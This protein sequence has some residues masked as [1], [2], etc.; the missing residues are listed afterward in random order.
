MDFY[1][2]GTPFEY[3]VQLVPTGASKNP[4]QTLL[5]GILDRG[6]EV[7][8]PGKP[9]KDAELKTA[10][11]TLVQ[12]ISSSSAVKDSTH[13]TVDW[14]YG[15]GRFS[16]VPLVFFLDDR[17]T[18][19]IQEGVYAVFLFR[20]DMSGVYLTFNQGVTAIQKQHGRK[21]A[22]QIAQ[23]QAEDLRTWCANLPMRGFKL[24]NAIDLHTEDGLALE[25]QAATIAHKLYERG[26]VPSDSEI[27][28]DVGGVLES[29]RRYA[30]KDTTPPR[31][32]RAWIF[33]ANP[34]LFD[35]T[36]AVHELPELTFEVNQHAKEIRKGDTAFLWASGKTAGVVAIATVI[37]DPA[38]G[39]QRAE[40][41]R[42]N[43]DPVRF[44]E[45]RARSV[46]RINYVPPELL[47]RRVLLD[48][49]VL[50]EIPIL[51]GP[52]GTNFGLTSEQAEILS[53]LVKERHK[54]D[55]VRST[56][57]VKVTAVPRL[58]ADCLAG[59]FIALDSIKPGGLDSLK[60][61]RAGDIVVAAR[62]TSEVLAVGEVI[63]PGY[64]W[65]PERAEG[66]HTVKV[67]WKDT[68]PKRIPRQNDWLLNEVAAIPESLLPL[69]L[70]PGPETPPNKD[71]K[72][73]L[74]GFNTAL[75][76][77]RL[78]FGNEDVVRSFV[79]GLATKRL[80]ILTG[81]SGSG[82]TQ[83]ALRFG[84]WFGRDQ[85]GGRRWALVP[86][87]PDW[88]GPE[89]LLGYEDAL[90]NSVGDRQVWHVP[91]VLDFILR[92]ARNPDYPYL[93]VLDEMN[94]A[95]VERYFADF[96]SGMESGAP[97]LPNLTQAGEKWLS[98]ADPS[99]QIPLPENVFVVGTV[100]VD[101]TTYMF[102]PKV[103][104][105]ANTYEFRVRTKDLA[106][107]AHKPLPCEPGDDALVRGFLAI[108]A[109][110]EWQ[111]EQPAPS[112]DQLLPRITELHGLL[113]EHDLE[114]GH[115]VFYDMIRFAAMLSAT[116]EK[117]PEVTLDRQVF[118]KVLP[119]LH[120]TRR[121]LEQPLRTLAQ[122][123][124]NLKYQPNVT[125][126]FKPEEPPK[127]KAALPDSFEKLQRM[128]KSLRINQFTSF[129][130]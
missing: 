52:Q 106:Q 72:Q 13:I 51:K 110:D 10:F 44:A 87:R 77:T 68:H 81:L 45:D 55:V 76:G 103:L 25:Y 50:K 82:K 69:V 94:L 105:R 60:A 16:A 107:V 115:R 117:R 63:S 114:F 124:F 32:P 123:C 8:E 121:R 7:F 36:D 119:R 61:L 46:L 109:D 2:T 78:T 53:A 83:L 34:E 74:A 118:Q 6:A 75:A 70:R 97:C 95:H 80:A 33:Q 86:V 62:G 19:S 12:T 100:N 5:Q 38:S 93:L 122:F 18:A 9:A 67:H 42:F 120:G 88:T 90:Q 56:V 96:L 85:D 54:P 108:A 48:H 47:P 58:W 127:G 21:M 128:Y 79:A 111:V 89:A 91:P 30:E 31:L 64:Q 102:S 92:A 3:R 104:D 28:A 4:I 17:I 116:D 99:D 65:Q 49:P 43:R 26:H 57:A 15:K 11:E 41:K 125:V 126:D 113:A 84:E 98:P 66:K 23:S 22:R 73:I 1:E 35:I 37:T 59:G 101:E 130:G 40:E 14:S 20:R 29:Y 24:D 27:L 39:S 112:L 129:T 71:L